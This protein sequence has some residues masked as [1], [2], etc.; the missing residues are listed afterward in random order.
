[1]DAVQRLSG[2]DRV[3]DFLEEIDP[4]TLVG[5]C[6]RHPGDPGDAVAVDACDDTVMRGR[7]LFGK[8]ANRDSRKRSLSGDDPVELPRCRARFEKLLGPLDPGSAA[9]RR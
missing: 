4:G 7:K 6:P 2:R 3:A 9:E 1:M 5:G 8:A